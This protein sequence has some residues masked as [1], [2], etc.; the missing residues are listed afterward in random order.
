MKEYILKTRKDGTSITVRD[1]QLV[2]L[3]MLKDIDALCKKH[4]IRYWLTGGSALGAV[5]HKGFIPWDDDADI[6]ML[7]EDYEKF[8]RVVHEL[9]DAYITQCF[10]THSKYNVLVPPMK[11]RKKGT[12]CVEYNA[13]LKNK[14]RDSDGLFIDIFVLD[15]VSENKA[16]DFIWRVRN[17]ILMV[18][19][20][21]FEN[22]HC[23]PL[24]LKRRF[25][26]NAKKYG[27][28]NKNTAWIGYDLTWTFNSF[29]H[30]VVYSLES[31]FPIQYVEFEDTM[32][33][34]PKRP[35]DML[36]VEVSTQHMSYPPLKDQA[37]KHIKDI[38][39][40]ASLIDDIR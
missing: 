37:P 30:P 14:C 13:L 39:L 24:L 15:H 32:L 5:R 36:D 2:L 18:L 27:Q 31:V 1:V 28:I 6:G 33:P 26:R 25:V 7:R 10:E 12:Y 11:V 3:E 8:Q 38:E 4:N 17:G 20:V 23:N 35:K 22:L 19:I 40:Q 9:G 29:F 21:F 16:K 34:V